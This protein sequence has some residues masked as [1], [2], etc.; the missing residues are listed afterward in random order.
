MLWAA[1]FFLLTAYVLGY[2]IE[3]RQF[4]IVHAT[5]CAGDKITGHTVVAGDAIMGINE[6]SAA[7]FTPLR[8][9][10]VMYWNAAHPVGSACD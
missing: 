2:G 3:R 7:F 8:L 1:V 6:I 4:H 10:E 9:L 5:S